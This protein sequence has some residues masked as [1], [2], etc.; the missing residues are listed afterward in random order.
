MATKATGKGR[1]KAKKPA[2]GTAAP[3]FKAGQRVQV[4]GKGSF[5]YNLFGKVEGVNG[6]TVS[7]LLDHKQA[8]SEFPA[9]Q[10]KA[11]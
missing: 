1:A 7:V 8:A 2:A 11:A 3:K 5:A 9:A 4:V 10:L 6:D